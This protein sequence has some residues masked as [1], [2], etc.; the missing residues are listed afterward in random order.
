MVE[1]LTKILPYLIWRLK[2][3]IKA[4]MKYIGLYFCLIFLCLVSSVQSYQPL[5]WSPVDLY[6]LKSVKNGP[7]EL[8]IINAEKKLLEKSLYTYNRRGRLLKEVYY[9]SQRKKTGYTKYFYRKGKIIRES[10]FDKS[11]KKL[12]SAQFIYASNGFLKELRISDRTGKI[13]SVQ[14]YGYVNTLLVKGVEVTGKEE[15]TFELLYEKKKL[16]RIIGKN[17]RTGKISE[18]FYKYGKTKYGKTHKIKER[19][20]LSQSKTSRCRYQYDADGRLIKLSYENKIQYINKAQYKKE[21]KKGKWK[22]EKEVIL[23]Y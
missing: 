1:I 13:R 8:K 23:L 22:I 2:E 20:L 5:R 7:S 12:R 15:N 9:N 17:K 6:I 3:D 21:T 11:G 10:L 14:S 4:A 16:K 18:I 19:I